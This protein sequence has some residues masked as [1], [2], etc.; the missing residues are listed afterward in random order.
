LAPLAFAAGLSGRAAGRGRGFV[1][2]AVESGAALGSSL[3]EIVAGSDEER[4][5]ADGVEAI[6]GTLAT[7]VAG[8]GAE[9]D[10]ASTGALV[11]R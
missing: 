1:E 7:L 10:G 3:G 2:L 8:S 5:A 4:A 6:A 9:A 11:A